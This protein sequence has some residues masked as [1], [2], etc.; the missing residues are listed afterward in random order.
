MSQTPYGGP[1]PPQRPGPPSYG[2]QPYGNQPYGQQPQPSYESYGGGYQEGPSEAANLPL[3]SIWRRA[4]ARL[5]DAG[6]TWAAGFAVVF[7]ITLGA[8]G[9][10]K[11]GDP[12]S[13]PILVTTFIV[14]SVLPFIY[15]AVL[16]TMSGQ[17]L[18]KRLL[19]LRV[20]DVDPAGEPI[21]MSKALW[22]SAIN[23]VV[24]QLGIFFFLLIGVTTPFVYALLGIFFAAIG[25]LVCYLW[26]IW[27]QPLHQAVH[28]R[29]AG[30]VV[31]DDRAEYVEYEEE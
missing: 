6:L 20:V 19:G 17:T 1:Y 5:A 21:G 24:Y 11:D 15:E 31:I 27:D 28:D 25:V 9:V 13:T 26:A 30:T 18:G 4:G 8:I 12:W 3:A 2:Q 10:K 14:M 29:F 16:L 23:N 22:R 7:P